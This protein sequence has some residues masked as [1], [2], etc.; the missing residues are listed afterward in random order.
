M[1]SL[2]NAGVDFRSGNW[3][4]EAGLVFVPTAVNLSLPNLLD[5]SLVLSRQGS[6]EPVREFHPLCRFELGQQ[7]VSLLL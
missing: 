7:H 2:A 4:A 1:Q 6:V 3:L 5:F